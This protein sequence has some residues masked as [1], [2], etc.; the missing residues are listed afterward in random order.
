MSTT[1][2]NRRTAAA[3]AAA[4]AT[5]DVAPDRIALRDAKRR[6][7]KGTAT[8]NDERRIADDDALKAGAKQRRRLA[9]LDVVTTNRALGIADTDPAAWRLPPTRKQRAE[10]EPG[11][12]A[13]D[14]L[15]AVPTIRHREVWVTDEE[16]GERTRLLRAD[17]TPVVVIE[18]NP[19][20]AAYALPSPHIS[21]SELLRLA[22]L[23]AG[24][25]PHSPGMDRDEMTSELA[26]RAMES[27]ATPA[28]AWCNVC[29]GPATY[30]VPMPDDY[31]NAYPAARC[32]RHARGYRD[33]RR[34]ALSPLPRWDALDR[35]DDA[36]KAARRDGGSD[37]KQ[38][39]RW[40][41]WLVQAGRFI[42]TDEHRKHGWNV[43]A[44]WT[45]ADNDDASE[46]AEQKAAA[47]AER[48]SAAAAAAVDNASHLDW[49]E[50][51]ADAAPDDNPLS[52]AERDALL[53]ALAGMTRAE[54]AALRGVSDETVKK[55]AQRG[56]KHLDERVPDARTAARWAAAARAADTDDGDAFLERVAVGR[57]IA[58]P[59]VP[60][61]DPVHL[62]WPERSAPADGGDTGHLPSWPDDVSAPAHQPERCHAFPASPLISWRTGVRP[63]GLADALP[64]RTFTDRAPARD[65]LRPML[66]AT[67][68][69]LPPT[70][71]RNA[72]RT[73]PASDGIGWMSTSGG[74]CPVGGWQ[75]IA[76]APRGIAASRGARLA[77][78]AAQLRDLAAERRR[79]LRLAATPWL[80]DW[81]RADCAQRADALTTNATA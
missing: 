52:G 31:G 13:R 41:G 78:D 38:R 19:N 30:A 72:A 61:A 58:Y 59:R 67:A 79:L 64:R 53:L 26:A 10:G 60:S 25:L 36:A 43:A 17:G 4:A 27:H 21:G 40:R 6:E 39:D 3:K 45:P 80:P 46:T 33:A 7:R 63:D 71:D 75:W 65:E 16:T 50:A 68:V 74:T 29:A 66:R 14:I 49:V 57:S 35:D 62:R 44:D 37:A 12:D 18:G 24:R 9:A 48:L 11:D 51:L 73:A 23:A 54:V 76:G 47:A 69:A 1:K 22:R 70:L 77:A 42:A 32:I 56:R 20:A 15:A 5:A 8:L 28:D 81:R 34:L 55:Q 2:Q